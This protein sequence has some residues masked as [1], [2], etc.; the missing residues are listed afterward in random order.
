M[1]QLPKKIV[2]ALILCLLLAS[3][4]ACKGNETKESETAPP[5]E[6]TLGLNLLESGLWRAACD[7]FGSSFKAA[8]EL[9]VNGEITVEFTMAKKDEES[10][11]WPYVELICET[12]ATLTGAEA[13]EIT[14]WSEKELTIKLS[15]SDFGSD[16]DSSYAHYQLKVPASEEWTTTTVYFKDFQQPGWA[17]EASKAVSLKLENTENIYLVPVLDYK[18]GET[19]KIGVKSLIL[20]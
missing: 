12:G 19:G 17:P 15:Q 9:I 10:N 6:A 20:R 1:R 4:F 2:P 8:E 3:L 16:G 14:Y 18:T 5:Q 11:N 7:N 13:V